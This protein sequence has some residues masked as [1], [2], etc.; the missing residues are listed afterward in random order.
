MTALALVA[1]YPADVLTV[2]AHEPPL[3]PVLP[4]AAAP[5]APAPRSGTRTRRAAGVP[6][7]RP[8]SP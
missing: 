2:V 5:S 3:I 4:D 6:A 7:W 1:R 8:S